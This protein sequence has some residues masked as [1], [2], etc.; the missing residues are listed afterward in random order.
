MKTHYAILLWA[1][2][3]LVG[4]SPYAKADEPLQEGSSLQ[5]RIAGLQTLKAQN[6]QAFQEK[7]TA[8]K[9]DITEKLTKLREDDPSQFQSILQEHREGTLQH[10]QDLRS[11]HPDQFWKALEDQRRALLDRAKALKTE[12]PAEYQKFMAQR[13]ASLKEARTRERKVSRRSLKE[14]HE[15]NKDQ[16]NA[17]LA[18]NGGSRSDLRKRRQERSGA[19]EDERFQRFLAAHPKDKEA[20]DN[21]DAEEKQKM[22]DRFKN[23]AG[24]GPGR[25]NLKKGASPRPE[26]HGEGH[27]R[28]QAPKTNDEKHKERINRGSD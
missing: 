7:I 11:D 9:K 6:P 18:R 23:R 17:A 4:F 27:N 14:R 19:G 2:C 22:A 3:L 5:D 21:A 1:G 28:T 15:L 20:W 25:Q 24:R 12:D 13:A 8:F 16:R 26:D 10:L